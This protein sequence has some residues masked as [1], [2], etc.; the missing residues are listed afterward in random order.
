[1]SESARVESIDALKHFRIALFKF[2]ESSNIALNDAESEMRKTM[3]WLEHEQYGHWQ[4]EIRKRHEMVERCKEAVRMKKL[5]RDSTGRQQSAVDEEK[6]LRLAMARFAEAEQ[7]F[8]NTKKY[9]RILAKEIEVYRGASQRF[10]TTVQVDIPQA[11]MNLDGFIVAL[12]EYVSLKG[13]DTGPAMAP[14]ETTPTEKSTATGEEGVG[15][16]SV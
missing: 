4:G 10:A 9:A 14:T 3:N 13:V 5:F 6:A 16:G 1:M 12:E 7:K 15:H 2:A 8:A 11:V